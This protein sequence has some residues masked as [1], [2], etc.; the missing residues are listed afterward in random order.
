MCWGR[1]FETSSF[2]S[3]TTARLDR[4]AE[5]VRERNDPRVRV[6]SNER[7]LGLARSLNRGLE[8]ARGELVARLDADDLC[9]PDRLL[10]QVAFM[11]AHPDVVLAGSWYVEMTADGAVGARRQLPTDHWDL[12]WQLC[13][14]CPFVHSAVIWR[15][16]TVAELVGHYDERLTYAMDYD[17]WRRIAQQGQVANL[18]KYLVH[19]RTHPASMTATYGV[20]A[21]EALA[22][23]AE[24]AAGL[25]GWPGGE[26]DANEHRIRQL[27]KLM[28]S[29]PAGRTQREL[30]S[31][32]EELI[33]FHDAFVAAERMPDSEARRQRRWLRARLARR[34]LRA[35]RTPTAEGR[36]GPSWELLRRATSLAPRALLTR[37]GLGACL[38]FVA[39]P[40]GST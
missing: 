21:R 40:W 22:M 6:I 33:R 5:I 20:R 11:D 29:A 17:L 35:S 15:R 26:R 34:L 8:E 19:V 2:S 14:F 38:R 4:T 7:N 3:W 18:P 27:Y 39:R 23:Q 13:V 9:V 10:H 36:R 32:A 37:D 25:L 24:Y 31:D 28:I 12:R 16:Q 30:I 1:A